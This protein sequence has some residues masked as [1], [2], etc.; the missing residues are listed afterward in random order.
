VLRAIFEYPPIAEPQLDTLDRPAS[1][2]DIST[3]CKTV[4]IDP[5]AQIGPG[6][7]SPWRTAIGGT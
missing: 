4:H 5:A 2:I 6:E 7:A 3:R 1:A